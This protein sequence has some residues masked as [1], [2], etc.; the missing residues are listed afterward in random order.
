MTPHRNLLLQHHKA[1]HNL[2]KIILQTCT[3]ESE[4]ILAILSQGAVM[5][6][7]VNA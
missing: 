6:S 5:L 7:S 1:I 4:I 2:E 3:P